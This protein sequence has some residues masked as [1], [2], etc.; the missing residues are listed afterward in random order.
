MPEP[1]VT[2]A[3]NF[4]AADLRDLTVALEGP[5]TG[6]IR[7][8]SGQ[9]VDLLRAAGI[10]LADPDACAAAAAV[11]TALAALDARFDDLSLAVGVMMHTVGDAYPATP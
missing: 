6:R 7:A 8:L 10:D 11:L 9:A 1:I 5:A 3:R 4:C 2:L